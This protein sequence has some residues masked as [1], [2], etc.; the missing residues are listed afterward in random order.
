MD[1]NIVRFVDKELLYC[2]EYVVVK[3]YVESSVSLLDA[4][5]KIAIGQSI[6]NPDVRNGNEDF[7]LLRKHLCVILDR[8]FSDNIKYGF[9]EIG[10]PCINFNFKNDG[11]SHLLCQIAGGQFDFDS[12][13]KCYVEDIV[14]P[15]WVVNVFGFTPKFGIGGIRKHVNKYGKPLLGGIIKPKIGMGINKL[16]DVIVEMVDGGVDF[17]KEDEI[18]SNQ[19]CCPFYKRID[20]ISNLLSKINSNV[21]YAFSI[22]SDVPDVISRAKSVAEHGGNAIHINVWSGIGIYRSIRSL[23]LS[24]FLFYQKSGDRIFTNRLN[25]FHID[26]SVMCKLAAFSGVDF[27]HAGMYNGYLNDDLNYLNNILYIL[28]SG[29]VMPSMSCG[30]HPGVVNGITDAIGN[31]Y[32]ANCGGSI[33]GHPGGTKSGAMAMRQAIDG[34]YGLEYKQAIELWGKK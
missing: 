25:N 33:H 19:D 14:F 15:E 3:Y 5:R 9:I 31:D 32:L 22:T 30:M 11:I 23:D 18:L 34:T 13:K 24:L 10:F 29:N 28:R 27:I 26:W 2:G 20:A 4:A 7:E 16:K 12:F 1:K 6:G 8:H 17:I 21:I